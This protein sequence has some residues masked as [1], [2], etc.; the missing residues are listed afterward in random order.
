MKKS[1]KQT[2]NI[3]E[4]DLDKFG[5]KG[6]SITLNCKVGGIIQAKGSSNISTGY[7]WEVDESLEGYQGVSLI[8]SD[9]FEQ[10]ILSIMNLQQ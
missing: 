1:S 4:V 8:S 10:K 9:Y 2:S 7:S 3:I 5:D 6:G